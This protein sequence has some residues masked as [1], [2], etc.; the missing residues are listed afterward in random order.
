MSHVSQSRCKNKNNRLELVLA[1][2]SKL[3]DDQVIAHNVTG[4]MYGYWLFHHGTMCMN[5]L[6]CYVQLYLRT[7]ITNISETD[8]CQN[9]QSCLCSP[10]ELKSGLSNAGF[11]HNSRSMHFTTLLNC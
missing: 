7:M 6:P 4:D 3:Y 5:T 10:Y 9:S 11:Q 1:A 8:F 2:F